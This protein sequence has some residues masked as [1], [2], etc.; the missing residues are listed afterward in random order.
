VIELDHNATTKP[1]PSA[2]A[3]MVDAL[4]ER[5]HNPSSVHRAGQAARAQ[6]E[7]ARADLAKLLHVSPRQLV[8]T[9]CGTES[10]NLAIRGWLAATS[11]GTK[12]ILL[13]SR[14]EHAAVRDLA[15]DL[16]REA[17]QSSGGCEVRW[18][19]IDSNGVVDVGALE[20]EFTAI[21]P[22]P[23]LVAAQ[24]A[25][26]ETGAIQPV[27]AIAAA[28][29]AHRA[30][31]LCDATQ[32]VGKMP[33]DSE[34]TCD[35]LVCSPHKFHGPKGVGILWSSSK[36]RWRPRQLGTQELGR[37]GGT[38][39]V[40]GIVGAAA[41]AR[42]A[43]GWLGDGLGDAGARERLASWR[44]HF[45]R[46]IIARVNAILPA[47]WPRAVVNA[48]GAPRLWNTTNIAFPRL[49]AEAILLAL[50][51][52]GVN[53]S[54]GAACSSGSLDPSPVLLAMGI[55]PELAHGSV[56]FSMSRDTTREEL[57][58]AADVVVEVVGRLVASMPG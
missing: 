5:W 15:E 35:L 40:P 54:A 52:R 24:W 22:R 38:E 51:E 33:I 48:A 50:S 16:A 11:P 2:V 31:F 42:D 30:T 10:I 1:T 32:W 17:A 18:L 34:P 45:E 14:V 3:A 49:E 29:K 53:A 23:C 55:D 26:N 19:A 56:R 12:P 44:D 20:R 57:A 9:S 6:V 13:T 36:A 43:I 4:Q 37:R 46:D 25:N 7:L 58:H 28:C 21:V 39:N 47:H 27:A 8:F 41:A